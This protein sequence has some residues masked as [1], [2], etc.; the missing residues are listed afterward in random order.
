MNLTSVLFTSETNS[1]IGATKFG[2]TAG[3]VYRS[4]AQ[5]TSGAQKFTFL[6]S[7]IA[8]PTLV[9]NNTALN[10]TL[11]TAPTVDSAAPA[12]A[13]Q[14]VSGFLTKDA[15]TDLYARYLE[16]TSSVP[17]TPFDAADPDGTS[18]LGV[19]NYILH[20]F[21]EEANTYLYSD[22]A[23]HSIDFTFKVTDGAG[24][25][26]NLTLTSD[27]PFALNGGTI[28]LLTKNYTK[29][30]TLGTNGGTFDIQ[31]GVTAQISGA[32]SGTGGLTKDGDGTLILSNASN[33]YGAT[34]INAGT[35]NLTSGLHSAVTVANTGTLDLR[36]SVTGNL[37]LSGSN[38][39]LNAYK[40]K[41]KA[42][43]YGYKLDAPKLKGDTALLELGLTLT[44]A[45]KGWSLDVGV[46]GYTGKR[47][48]VTGNVKA[49]YRF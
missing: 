7:S 15:T 12:G 23:S 41:A 38:S 18:T 37:T 31:N 25:V 32:I 8:T 34:T 17:V 5:P 22:F 42:S 2:V 1:A 27:S 11:A 39:T 49:G 46:Q 16:T 28:G 9:L 47:E 30:W 3:G 20:I 33:S 29:A 26:Q 36:G 43:I 40:G 13:A 24:T 21:S 14:Y 48:G 44:P 19:G 4:A 35:L 6:T 10:F 45:E